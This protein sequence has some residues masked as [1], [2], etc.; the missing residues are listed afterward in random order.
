MMEQ[1]VESKNQ[2]SGQASKQR[3]YLIIS[4]TLAGIIILGFGC[5]VLMAEK[6]W[7]SS[8][9]LL[10]QDVADVY[11]SDSTVVPASQM[12]T[13]DAIF[14]I[15]FSRRVLQT[16]I[17]EA[18][19]VWTPEELREMTDV[20]ETAKGSNCFKIT[21]NS[22]DRNMSAKLVNTLAKVFL[23]EY[24]ALINT[25]VI[26]ARERT[27]SNIAILK[28]ELQISDAGADQIEQ[29]KAEI[30]RQEEFAGA[31]KIFLDGKYLDITIVEQGVPA[32]FATRKLFW[33]R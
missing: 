23:D 33:S 29:K 32:T 21:V 9:M 31:L 24:K 18:Q 8:A 22:P 30:Q 14:E 28:N 13:M 20:R 15:I 7:A 4:I 16:A 2:V 3:Q 19:A 12:I 11:Q 5:S 6:Q 17:N 1:K 10:R 26:A 25:G 27:L